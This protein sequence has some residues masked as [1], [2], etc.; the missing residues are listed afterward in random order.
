MFDEVREVFRRPNPQLALIGHEADDV[1]LRSVE[2]DR[3]YSLYQQL[4]KRR[5][6]KE[7]RFSGR[8]FHGLST[9]NAKGG[10]AYHVGDTT[11]S[12]T[13][14]ALLRCLSSFEK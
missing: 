3:L 11:R 10:E 1:G 13:S 14:L 9:Q 5:F 6:L 4:F 7:T 8:R 12:H 2:V